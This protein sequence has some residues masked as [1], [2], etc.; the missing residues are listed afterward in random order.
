MDGDVLARQ[1]G[2][3][4][5][6]VLLLL[7]DGP[8][9]AQELREL[10]G[11]IGLRQQAKRL[12]STLQELEAAALIEGVRGRNVPD[13]RCFALTAEGRRW[14]ADRSEALAEP[15]RLMARFL[16]RYTAADA[17]GSTSGEEEGRDP[18]NG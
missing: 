2:F 14:L 3:V 7:Q 15:A 6:C 8:R 16:T 13:L 17:V 1:H 11:A 12:D 5:P 10:V 4:L 18:P 9:G